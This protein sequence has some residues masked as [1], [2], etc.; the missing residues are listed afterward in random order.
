MFT[1]HSP[2]IINSVWQWGLGE[3]E[4]VSMLVTVHVCGVN[5]RSGFVTV[6]HLQQHAICIERQSSGV[7]VLFFVLWLHTS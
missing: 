3:Y 4:R 2:K 6:H 1:Q 7:P 5:I